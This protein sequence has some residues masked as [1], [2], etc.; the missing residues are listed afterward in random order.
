MN[1][2]LNEALDKYLLNGSDKNTEACLERKPNQ[3][4]WNSAGL[5]R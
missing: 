3:Q 1:S 4:S 2:G 5:Q